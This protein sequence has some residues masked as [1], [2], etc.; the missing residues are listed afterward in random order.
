MRKEGE[1]EVKEKKEREKKKINLKR[2]SL[3]SFGNGSATY[4]MGRKPLPAAS[5]EECV[6]R[7]INKWPIEFESAAVPFQIGCDLNK[8]KGERARDGRKR[9]KERKG[10]KRDDERTR[11]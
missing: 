10:N 1:K 6:H 9:R 4:S 8:E 7:C 2:N 3:A 11:E 5:N